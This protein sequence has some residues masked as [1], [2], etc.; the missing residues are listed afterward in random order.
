MP[1]VN[2]ERLPSGHYFACV[3]YPSENEQ[4]LNVLNYCLSHFKCVYILHQ[5]EDDTKK[6]HVHLLFDTKSRY[7][8]NGII[9]F[10]AGWID[11]VELLTNPDAYLRYMLHDTPQAIIDGK[12]P[13]SFDDLKGD[14]SLK[15]RIVQNS[16]F[17]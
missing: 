15:K 10:F 14:E 11:Y 7:T 4:H 6:E 16:N 17:V 2:A 12:K 5:P 1:R 9:R 3:I 8:V 13:Y